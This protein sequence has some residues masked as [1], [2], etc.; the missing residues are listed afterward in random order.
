MRGLLICV[1]LVTTT[2]LG[3]GASIPTLPGV[4]PAYRI[5]LERFVVAPNRT[6]GLL[7]R[8]RI[9]GG[10]PL[11]LLVDSGTQYV[12][13]DRT[14]AVRSRCQGGDYLELVGAGARKTATVTLLRADSLEAGDLTLHDIPL[15]IADRPLPD[16][17][18]GAVPLSIFAGFL[19]RLNIPAKQLDLLPYAPEFAGNAGALEI[20]SDNGLAFVKATVNETHEGYF[21]LDTGSAYT[22]ISQNVARQLHVSE[23]LSPHVPLQGGIA[24]INAPL[25]SGA[26]RVRLPSQ[27]VVAGPVVAVDLSTASRYHNFEVSGL[28]G[29]SAL[30][31]SVLTLNYRDLALRIEPK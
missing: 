25:V 2:A 11:R 1:G 16:G 7:M 6:A 12:V 3:T 13:L 18:Q 14:S 28:L 27:R 15:V 21:L 4:S 31:D 24:A 17:A 26:V 5:K 29:Y 22:A 19:I 20:L 8:V 10:P 30:C 9:N 23:T